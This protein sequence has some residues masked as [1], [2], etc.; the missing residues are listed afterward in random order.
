MY[1]K[2][3]ERISQRYWGIHFEY[4][5]NMLQEAGCS[6]DYYTREDDNLVVEVNNNR[7]VDFNYWDSSEKYVITGIP[8]FKFHCNQL[9][10]NIFS[11]SPVSFYDWAHY[12]FLRRNIK[13]KAKGIISCRQRAYAGALERRTTVQRLLRDYYEVKMN[14]ITQIDF[15]QEIEDCLVAVCVPGFCNNMLDRGQFQYM[16][17][18]ACTISPEI[19]EYLP[20]NQ[21]LISQEHYIK[22]ANDYSD[23]IEKIE[24]CRNNTTKCINIGKSAQDLFLKTSVPTKTLEWIKIK[25]GC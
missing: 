18:G 22:C 5:L 8:V 1:I 19:P 13:Y 2:F 6:I 12:D 9:K 21:K 4:V 10:D 23:L 7:W 25:S 15:W 24:W 17:L 14:E 3:P 16:A 20:F 11:F